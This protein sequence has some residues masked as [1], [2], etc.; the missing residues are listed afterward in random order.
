MGTVFELEPDGTESVLYSFTVEDNGK[1]GYAPIGALIEDRAGN[2]Y[3]AATS[4]GGTADCGTI[5]KLAP[6][7]V[8][9]VI[10]AFAGGSDGCEPNAGLL[11]DK[12]GTF[13]GTTET[14]GN[15]NGYQCEHYGC[16]TVFRLDSNHGIT[17]LYAF[18]GESD[19]ALPN[20]PL[21]SDTSGN[22][23]GT[24][25]GPGQYDSGCA[26]GIG[27]CGT[28]FKV[29]PDGTETVLYVFCSVQYC[30]DG[31]TPQ[32]GLIA[33]SNGNLYG[34]TY[35]GGPNGGGAVF[36]LALDG[37]ETVLFSFNYTDGWGPVGSLVT[38]RQGSFYGTTDAG[39][40][41]CKGGAGCGVIFKVTPD[42]TGTTLFKFNKEQAN[43][44]NGSLILLNGYLYG[45]T[46][47]GGNLSACPKV[48]CGTVFSIQK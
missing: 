41:R 48:G 29:A 9:K 15:Y 4:G 34:T 20:G 40:A 31:S 7:G 14:G 10:H 39:G 33:D 22:L 21:I 3:G 11:A 19:G 5:F 35:F 47:S 13:Y 6:G 2:F 24:T 44:P 46:S 1:D 8:E 25:Y 12:H 43:R 45:T 30:A 26:S 42:G 23:Y 27:P 32:G 18:Q 28:V 37:T 17:V 36:K 16:G 38:D